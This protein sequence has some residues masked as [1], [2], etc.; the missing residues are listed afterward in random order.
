[1]LQELENSEEIGEMQVTNIDDVQ[2]SEETNNGHIDQGEE[3]SEGTEEEEEEEEEEGRVT[4]MPII[5]E[6]LSDNPESPRNKKVS[7]NGD[8]SGEGNGVQ[9]NGKTE[10]GDFG[11][12]LDGAPSIAQQKRLVSILK[13]P[14]ENDAIKSQK[15]K[16]EQK[17]ERE[18]KAKR[19]RRRKEKMERQKQ[20]EEKEKKKK[21]E[22]KSKEKRIEN[23]APESGGQDEGTD[24]QY[25]KEK[26]GSG[27]TLIELKKQRSIQ[28]KS[29]SADG[30]NTPDQGS[31][32][33]LLSPSQ[34]YR[35]EFSTV[36]LTIIK[37]E[38]Y[39]QSMD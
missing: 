26:A 32:Y 25:Y 27:T 23:E 24:E 38:V 31:V 30:D 3:K 13:R 12:S 33:Q 34:T 7:N 6:E 36:E 4:P 14:H 18:K 5:T 22:Q 39:F 9:E 35:P 15:S 28:K 10:S 19:S 8:V 2:V 37:S 29:T 21:K 16:K 20:K 1:M 17:E 11:E